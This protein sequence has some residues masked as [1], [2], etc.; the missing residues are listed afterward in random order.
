[1]LKEVLS[2]KWE[3]RSLHGNTDYGEPHNL[4]STQGPTEIFVPCFDCDQPDSVCLDGKLISVAWRVFVAN[5]EPESIAYQK[6]QE[7]GEHYGFVDLSSMDQT[8][9]SGFFDHLGFHHVRMSAYLEGF[10]DAKC[11]AILEVEI[12]DASGSPVWSHWEYIPSARIYKTLDDDDESLPYEFCDLCDKELTE[13]DF[14]DGSAK[15]CDECNGVFCND[16]MDGNTTCPN[17]ET[18]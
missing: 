5:D 7:L 11:K 14:T 1:M 6:F 15:L 16:C 18:L 13:E 9:F 2:R 4:R 10:H 8:W 17:C 3:V 12:L